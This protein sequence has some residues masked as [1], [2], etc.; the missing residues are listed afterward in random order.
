MASSQT[1]SKRSLTGSC[2]CGKISYKVNLALTNPPTASRCNCKACEKPG[3]TAV[4][5]DPADFTLLS[6]ASKD[7]LPDFKC[8]S[9]DGHRYFCDEC[10]VQIYGEGKVELT[11]GQV[12]EY[13][14]INLHS[15]DQPQ[16]GLDL[17][18]FKIAYYD[19]RNDNWQARD[20][21]GP[22]GSA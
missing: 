1:A 4:S 13:F 19:G 12:H 7:Q 8:R 21:P 22:G 20:V 15:F 2:I 9:R 10:G 16:D 14:T 18:Q 3:Y 5:A 11:G 17:A 6:P